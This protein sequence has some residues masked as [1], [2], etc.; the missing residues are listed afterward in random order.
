MRTREGGP[1]LDRE[2]IGDVTVVR[3]RVLRYLVDDAEPVFG[4]IQGLVADAGRSRLVLNLAPV[5]F[6]ASVPFGKLVTLRRQ[7]EAKDGRLALCE[8]S[9]GVREMLDLT[10]LG[11]LLDIYA[12]EEEA[13]RSF[14]PSPR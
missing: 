11:Q 13:V 7:A 10:R 12:T 14:T 2:D 3:V 1:P 8:L 5:Q 4:P 6:L 9:P